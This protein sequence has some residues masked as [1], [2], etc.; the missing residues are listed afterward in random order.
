[1]RAAVGEKDDM[2]EE[3]CCRDE[4]KVGCS[5]SSYPFDIALALSLARQLGGEFSDDSTEVGVYLT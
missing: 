1:M 4:R 5:D 3:V 2:I